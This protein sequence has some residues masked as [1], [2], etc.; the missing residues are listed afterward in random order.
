MGGAQF[1]QLAFRLEIPVE[2]VALTGGRPQ[3][4][5]AES[6]KLR[7]Q[8]TADGLDAGPE[9]IRWHLEREGLRAPS[10]S[11]VF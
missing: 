2:T 11:T 5:R 6:E 7:A 10:T 9:T 3:A 8:L 4:V 1:G